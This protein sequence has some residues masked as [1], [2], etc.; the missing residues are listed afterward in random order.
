[1]NLNPVATA[2]GSVLADP[3]CGGFDFYRASWQAAKN[4]FREN[5]FREHPLSG[6]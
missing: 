4:F 5:L 3:Q 1:M 2:P 6:R